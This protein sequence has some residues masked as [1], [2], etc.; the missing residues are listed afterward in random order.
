MSLTYNYPKVGSVAD[1]AVTNDRGAALKFIA[2]GYK[3]FTTPQMFGKEG[4]LF[5]LVLV[6][7][8]PEASQKSEGDALQ[9]LSNL[10]AASR[11]LYSSL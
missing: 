3:I 8:N 6:D 4:G 7:R 9:I 10:E 1:I 5:T 11:E 2:K